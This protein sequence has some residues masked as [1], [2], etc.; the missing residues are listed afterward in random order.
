MKLL[1]FASYEEYVQI[2]SKVNRRKLGRIWITDDELACIGEFLR[3]RL[4]D[5]S[6]GICHGVRNGYEVHRFRRILGIE[7]IGTEISDSAAQFEHVIQWDFHD[8][9]V[10][11]LNK[12]DFVYSNSWDHS[13]DPDR[14]LNSWMQC[15][16]PDGKC[17]LEWTTDHGERGVKGA[18]CF[19]MS[20]EEMCAWVGREFTVEQILEVTPRNHNPVSLG[21][22]GEPLNRFRHKQG[23]HVIVAARRPSSDVE[24]SIKM[25]SL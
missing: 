21:T 17:L 4:K 6:F 10:A 2:Q 8:V 23:V 12:A 11:W 25:S 20:L 15:L 22:G 18:D 19:G 7:V 3:G 24:R 1:K 14:M 9:K 5:M 13:F 16:K